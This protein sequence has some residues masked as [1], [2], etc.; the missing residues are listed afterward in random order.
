MFAADWDLGVDDEAHMLWSHNNIVLF[1]DDGSGRSS[2]ER[3][4]D[5]YEQLLTLRAEDGSDWIV[6]LVSATNLRYLTR[7]EFVAAHDGDPAAI[8]DYD[9]LVAGGRPPTNWEVIVRQ[10]D[11][12]NITPNQAQT[13]ALTAFLDERWT[14]ATTNIPG[15]TAATL[16]EGTVRIEPADGPDES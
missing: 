8:G 5:L 3:A 6:H 16:A 9:A 14:A 12:F 4:N 13:D 15:L 7:D 1:T 11:R 2:F 10:V